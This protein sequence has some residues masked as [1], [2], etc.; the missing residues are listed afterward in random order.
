M[1]YSIFALEL[2]LELR[3][4]PALAVALA[5]LVHR[6]PAR[7]TRQDKWALYRRACDLLLGTLPWAAKGCWDYFDDDARARRDYDMWVNGLLTEEGARKVPSNGDAYRSAAG[8]FFMTFTM[9][10]LLARG[11]WTDR[12]MAAVCDIP[13]ADLWRRATFDRILRA[14]PTMDFGSVRSDVAYVIP[15]DG[16]FALTQEDLADPKFHYLRDLV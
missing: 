11:S 14:V 8:P 7:P 12:T 2:C 1:N 16:R 15:W 13:Q 3:D 4:G 10:F 9:S 6:H 5:D